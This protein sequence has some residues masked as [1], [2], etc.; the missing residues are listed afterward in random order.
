MHRAVLYFVT[1][2]ALLLGAGG[3]A[4]VAVATELLMVE[5]KWCHWCEQWNDEVGIIYH[6]TEEGKAAPLRRIDIHEPLPPDLVLASRPR[7]TPT[8]ILID[9]GRELS[10]IE[11][12]P[13]EAFFW[14]LLDR[15]LGEVPRPADAALSN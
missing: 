3:G 5:E 2:I 13:G 4:S 11:G 10:R 1:A 8:F 12:Y 9:N 15:M 14:G 7:Y 6:K